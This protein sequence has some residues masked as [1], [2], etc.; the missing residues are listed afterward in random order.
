M[1]NPL[2][3][4]VYDKDNFKTVTYVHSDDFGILAKVGDVISINDV[5]CVVFQIDAHPFGYIVFGSPVD[6]Q[7]ITLQIAYVTLLFE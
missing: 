7:N 6:E 2:S 3:P 4:Y 5:M 1:N